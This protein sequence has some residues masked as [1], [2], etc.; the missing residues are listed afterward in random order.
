[1]LAKALTLLTSR[2]TV[3]DAQL[4]YTDAAPVLYASRR[5]A[6]TARSGVLDVHVHGVVE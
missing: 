1:M 3:C 2:R 4:L 5:V 6:V